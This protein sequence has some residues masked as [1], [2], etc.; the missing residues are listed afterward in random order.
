MAISDAIIV[1]LVGIGVVFFGLLITSWLISA[2]ALVPAWLERRR[3]H[4][5][6]PPLAPM[7]NPF[8]QPAINPP[9]PPDTAAVIAALLE[10]E[11]RLHGGDQSSRFTFRRDSQS[12]A[13]SRDGGRCDNETAR[14]VK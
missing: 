1:S 5:V 4:M 9:P 13:W 8:P 11:M 2:I 3:K 12:R 14:G 7:A 10:V 6:L